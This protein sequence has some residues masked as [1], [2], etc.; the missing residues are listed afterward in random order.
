L[1]GAFYVQECVFEAVEQKQAMF[2]KLNEELDRIGA[3][4]DVIL[5]SSTSFN[6]PS[7]FTG[8]LRRKARAIVAHPVRP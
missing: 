6:A 5:A 8:D 1:A 2:K 4:E 7:L 3:A